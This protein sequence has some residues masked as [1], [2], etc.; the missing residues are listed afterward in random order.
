MIA[1][2]TPASYNARRRSGGGATNAVIAANDN[3]GRRVVVRI[4]APSAITAA[5]IEV[6][7]AIL[8]EMEA[9]AANEN[10]KQIALH[11]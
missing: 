3:G 10:K 9:S 5:E 11:V 2:T 8:M 6:F 4:I 7:G 1:V